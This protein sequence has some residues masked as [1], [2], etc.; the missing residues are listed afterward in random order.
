MVRN[1]KL[2]SE[3]VPNALLNEEKVKV[4]VCS[5]GRNG[6]SE[7]FLNNA[8]KLG[9][10]LAEQGVA[11]GNGG[12]AAEDTLMGATCSGYLNNGGNAAY[13]IERINGAPDLDS[14]V[15]KL[16][17]L[18]AVE[19]IGE[20]IKSQFLYFDIIVILPGG[21][22]TLCELISQP[23]MGY[24]YEDIKSKK[25]IIFNQ[26]VNGVG[27]FD[28]MLNQIQTGINCG[29]ISPGFINNFTIINDFDEL[30]STLTGIIDNLKSLKSPKI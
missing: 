20:L 4:F 8:R 10:F 26:Q 1:M 25:V 17:G 15:E 18:Y 7:E 30:V 21:S 11:Y 22:G 14:V 24:D 5:S 19:D 6:V 29:M 3:K 27:F 12:E 13:M 28:G 23:E 16:K 9:V 2:L